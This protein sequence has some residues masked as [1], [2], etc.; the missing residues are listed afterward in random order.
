M[1]KYVYL[2]EDRKEFHLTNGKISYIFRVMEQTNVLEQLYVGKAIQHRDS[3]AHLIEREVRPSNNQVVNDYT[4]SLE[5]VK[6]EMPA[7]GTTDFRYPAIE[8][9]YPDGD[10]ISHFEYQTFTIIEGKKKLEGMPATFATSKEATTLEIGLK[11]RY[12]EVVDRKS[13]V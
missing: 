7:Y 10:H 3:F 8:L 13:V 12:S 4:T 1:N 9:R 6:Q 5:H 2:N 11:D